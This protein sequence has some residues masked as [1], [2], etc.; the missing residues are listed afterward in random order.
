[1]DMRVQG[2]SGSTSLLPTRLRVPGPPIV[3]AVLA[4]VAKV[5]TLEAP[6]LYMGRR[7]VEGEARRVGGAGTAVD[8]G[9]ATVLASGVAGQAGLDVLEGLAVVAGLYLEV[10]ALFFR[11]DN[12]IFSLLVFFEV[13]G[14]EAGGKGVDARSDLR[15]REVGGGG[16][17]SGLLVS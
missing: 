8:D 15:G 13:A 17:T 3:G 5:A 1:M 12:P 14:A 6:L 11:A 16:V 4:D 2:L 7:G 9:G 10:V